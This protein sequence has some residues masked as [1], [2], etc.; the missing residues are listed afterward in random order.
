MQ[1]IEDLILE[2]F[3]LALK[4]ELSLKASLSWGT[5]EKNVNRNNNHQEITI[6]G[7]HYD[8]TE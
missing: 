8:P 4:L 3:M 1:R 2:A 7:L 6:D 5:T